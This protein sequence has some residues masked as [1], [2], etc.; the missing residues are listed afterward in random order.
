MTTY[1]S[2]MQWLDSQEIFTPPFTYHNT[3]VLY[4]NTYARLPELRYKL[5]SRGY[6]V[7][8][9]Q[10]KFHKPCFLLSCILMYNLEAVF[11]GFQSV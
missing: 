6:L 4:Y 8:L 1:G 11:L 5:L 7:S 10:T 3:K 2:S 9:K